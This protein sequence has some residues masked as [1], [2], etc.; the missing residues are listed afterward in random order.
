MEDD[1]ALDL[2]TLRMDA[3]FVKVDFD[4]IQWE[5]RREVDD[6]FYHYAENRCLKGS[7]SLNLDD[8]VISL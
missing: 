3:I 2:V 8:R 6:F 5:L 4:L 1:T 7:F